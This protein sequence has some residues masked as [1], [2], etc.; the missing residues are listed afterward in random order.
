MNNIVTNKIKHLPKLFALRPQI[1]LKLKWHYF[2][3][4]IITTKLDMGQSI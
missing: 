1:A 4:S 3:L 2:T